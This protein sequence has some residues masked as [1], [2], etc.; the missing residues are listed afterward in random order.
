MAKVFDT[1]DA[2]LAAWI[3]RQPMFFVA[4]APLA[5]DGHVNL[6]PRGKDTLSVLG[7]TTLGWVDLTGSGVETIAHLKENGR[8]TVMWCAFDGPPRVVRVHG[9]GTT[10]LPG[11]AAYDDVTARHPALPN[12]RAVITVEATRISDACGYGVPLMDLRG[13][14]DQMRRWSEAKGPEGIAAYTADRNAL[15]LDGLPGLAPSSNEG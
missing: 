5:A 2:D 7:P 15:S 13:E 6:S 9:R 3:S 10:H 4:T 1:I 8:I 12:T 11:T 14:R